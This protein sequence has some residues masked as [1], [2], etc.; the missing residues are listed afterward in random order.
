MSSTHPAQEAGTRRRRALPVLFVKADAVELL[1]YQGG[2]SRVDRAP[3]EAPRADVIATEARRL[4]ADG[5]GRRSGVTVVLGEGLFDTQQVLLGKLPDKEVADVLQRKAANALDCEPAEA[6]FV[7]QRLVPPLL[8][9]NGPSESNW[10]LHGRTRR[11]H[12][13]LLF[14][15]RG[16][17]VRAEHV[18]CLRDALPRLVGGRDDGA[19]VILLSYDGETVLTHLMR[20]GG[21]V[22]VSRLRVDG[23]DLD[24]GMTPGAP[25]NP[26]HLALVQEVRQVAAFWSK[27]SRGAPIAELRTVGIPSADL[28]DLRTPL[29][30]AAQGAQIVDMGTA[31]DDET[32]H[33]RATFLEALA[34]VAGQARNLMLPLPARRSRVVAATVAA[35]ALAGLF[36]WSWTLHWKERVDA[37]AVTISKLDQD[38]VALDEARLVKVEFV[39]AQSRFANAVRSLESLADEGVPFEGAVADLYDAVAAQADLEHVSI[40]SDEIAGTTELLAEGRI[41]GAPADITSRLAALRAGLGADPRLADVNVEPSSRVPAPTPDGDSELRFT[42]TATH[43]DLERQGGQQ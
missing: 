24:T 34:K 17:N 41:V 28:E 39:E 7:A 2:A 11:H 14:A 19:G 5:P 12:R 37:R 13:E 10:I 33:V 25:Q 30:I 21:L 27:S 15:L 4:L 42:L 40:G 18:V 20:D 6:L 8:S 9:E 26:L 1:W 32:D 29:S 22:Q 16:A 31:V 3:I 38:A 35:T 23:G 36:G 43:V